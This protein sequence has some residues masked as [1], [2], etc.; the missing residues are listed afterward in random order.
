MDQ[1][2]YEADKMQQQLLEMRT[3]PSHSLPPSQ[4][5]LLNTSLEAVLHLYNRLG[6]AQNIKQ[7]FKL[8][9]MHFMD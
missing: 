9:T 3:N 2:T 4:K 6:V 1:V 7:H 5:L 8:P